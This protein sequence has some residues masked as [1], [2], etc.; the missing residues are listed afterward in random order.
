GGGGG[1]AGGGGG[2]A[3]GIDGTSTNGRNGGSG[4]AVG[5]QGGGGGGGCAT[6]S[7]IAGGTGG[8]AGS[9]GA[10]S[11]TCTTNGLGGAV[12]TGGNQA[13]GGGGSSTTGSGG[14]GGGGFYGN[15]S[16]SQI[17][18]GSGGGGGGGGAQATGGTGGAGGT[19]GGI[20]YISAS[21]V[22]AT[23]S[24][25]ATGSAGYV[26]SASGGASGGGGAGGSVY[27]NTQT[28]TGT[29][30]SLVTALGG[31]GGT[32]GNH[33]AGGG[34]GGNGRIFIEYTDTSA[35]STNPTSN[36]FQVP[37]HGT[38]GTELDLSSYLG[39]AIYHFNDGSG[40]IV[41]EESNGVTGTI[42]GG[43]TWKNSEY[44]ISDKCLYLDGANGTVTMTNPLNSV[45]TISFWVNPST[46]TEPLIDLNGSA[47][48]QVSSG[49]ISATG[50][51]SPTIYVNGKVSSTLLA[52]QWQIVTVTS[53]TAVVP[54][55]FTVGKISTSYGQGF[56]D[57]LRIFNTEYSASQI[58]MLY[59]TPGDSY[60]S[61][62]SI[63]SKKNMLLDGLVGYWKMD[64]TTANTCSGGVND[65]CD[66][67]GN[68]NDIAWTNTT[69]SAG[70]FGNGSYYGGSA[71]SSGPFAGISSTKRWT[72]SGWFKTTD[73]LAYLFDSRNTSTNGACLYTEGTTIGVCVYAN[74]TGN[75]YK[76]YI[77]TPGT[78]VTDGNWHFYVFTRD[79]DNS[80]SLYIDN[81]KLTPSTIITDND[82]SSYNETWTSI[83]LGDRYN[84]L[85][86]YQ[87][88]GYLDEYR[89][90]NRALTSDEMTKLYTY[91][92]EPVVF[93]KFDENS[94]NTVYDSSGNNWSGTLSNSPT[95]TTGKF[96]S[97]LLF[98]GSSQNVIINPNNGLSATSGSISAWVYPTVSSPTAN[99]MI[100]E[101]NRE[102]NRIYLTRLPTTGNLGISLGNN[103]NIDSGIVIP[104]N[105]WSYV[106]MTWNSG[107][108]AIYFNGKNVS[109]STYSGLT[110]LDGYSSIGSYSDLVA[111][112]SWFTG[113]IDAVLM[114]NYART[115]KQILEDMNSGASIT[116]NTE[117]TTIGYWKF[118]DGIGTTAH[119][120]SIYQK[121]LTLSSSSAW[122]TAGKFDGAYNGSADG[123]RMSRAD[124][125]DFDFLGTDS[126][127]ISTWFKRSTIATNSEYIL[128]KQA[129]SAG[130]TIYMDGATGKI[131]F[132]TGSGTGVFPIDSIGTYAPTRYDNNAWHY[133]TAIKN[134]STSI[135]L[136]IDGKL[137]DSKTSLTG[138]GS[139]ANTGAIYI[140]DANN[141]N[142]TDEFLGSIDEMKI[143]R[144]ALSSDEVLVD[145]NR[146]K[147]VVLGALSTESDGKTLA[148][149]SDRSFCVPGDTTAC[150]PPV[151][152]WNFDENTGTTLYDIS[153][154]K[155]T[156]TLYNSPSWSQG[157]YGSALNF[158]L[159]SLQYV[160]TTSGS[161]S[162]LNL[163]S[164]MTISVWIKPT[165]VSV[166]STTGWY[167][168][169]SNYDQNNGLSQY[170]LGLTNNTG[171][172]N[173]TIVEF[174]NGI[175]NGTLGMWNDFKSSYKPTANV[176][177]HIVVT[178]DVNENVF[179]Y[180]NGV[181]QTSI[182]FNL[183]GVPPTAGN[184]VIGR[185]FNGNQSFDGLIDEL[186]MYNYVRTP[187]QIAWDYNG[188]KPIGQWRFDECQGTTAYDVTGNGRNATITIGATGSYTSVGTC[189]SGTST[190][191]WNAGTTGKLNNAIAFDGS[192]DYASTSNVALIGVNSVTYTNVSWGGWFNPSSTPTSKTL[193]HKGN[194]FRLTT[195]SSNQ[196][197]CQIY[198]ASWQT[199][200]TSTIALDNNTW[201]H[202][203][204]VYN[205]TTL[206][207]YQNGKEVASVARTNNITS[208]STTPVNIGR[209][210]AGTGYF[211]GL[212]DDVRIY[213]Y[214]LTPQQVQTAMNDDATMRIAQ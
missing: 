22:S 42:T 177:C 173:S 29:W 144:G 6:T 162:N 205:G 179:F 21:T 145:Y 92:P 111:P 49:T 146:G 156:G 12:A 191:A 75:N 7:A 140:G 186:K 187:A 85:Y 163:P 185:D 104:I 204:C 18:F 150:T 35:P 131:I 142:G 159:S 96:G 128:Y 148:N 46:T 3:G 143:Y 71:H 52:N 161:S 93:L 9:N 132:G 68:N 167:D 109:T 181:K 8:N 86:S 208:L 91:A 98:N 206:K 28:D 53:A 11:T 202:I 105:T 169:V 127:S 135:S 30:T 97:A 174:A 44:C 40:S 78:S 76:D 58:R 212:I 64:E 94:G 59:N 194:E 195:N 188:G 74:G 99:E 25:T 190:Q 83:T 4:G 62:V 84:Y 101:G 197:L 138:T 87:F 170:E 115:Q 164:D 63:G 124:D 103:S 192:D 51:T 10:A 39:R 43:V 37:Y 47:Y 211:P 95:W 66:S 72:I 193:I 183:Y 175:G 88:T 38:P 20:I 107:T 27:I 106:G 50:F 151:A 126:F 2:G 120:S 122:T 112:D 119:D 32:S 48:I 77:Y 1:H 133:L 196:P 69:S 36:L 168:I 213:T 137:V 157:K 201:S 108:Y 171:T 65:N 79:E 121:D 54:S 67:S 149:S 210:S 165:T 166:S 19:G 57:E 182:D 45:K 55:T 139:L 33:I 113:K 176:W 198:S 23:G 26:A 73:T 34:N 141:T 14:G 152:Y 31:T 153:S 123:M 147:S 102:T 82:M 214:A 70:K 17:Y 16:A 13:S 89:V 114:Y 110:S 125:N 189:S 15:T 160:G 136:Y 116:S 172:A 5:V 60:G 155:N 129:N 134:G 100:V 209:D 203:M 56:F 180:I 200:A 207:T 80:I 81:Q 117:N 158:S 118:D 90:Y 154:N 178:R 199:G 41:K 184:A 24:I 130:Y 61:A